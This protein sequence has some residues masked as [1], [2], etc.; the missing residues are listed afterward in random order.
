M[1]P[2][3]WALTTP[4]ADLVDETVSLTNIHSHDPHVAV[5]GDLVGNASGGETI[6]TSTVGPASVV[7]SIAVEK[8]SEKERFTFDFVNHAVLLREAL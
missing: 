2:G 6:A 4:S 1:L 8:L 5:G 7:A 3:H